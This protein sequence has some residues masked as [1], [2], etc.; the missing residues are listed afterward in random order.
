MTATD[1]L[2][3]LDLDRQVDQDQGTLFDEPRRRLRGDPSLRAG[4]AQFQAL[5][6]LAWE[7]APE[8]GER[9]VRQAVQQARRERVQGQ[10][11][12]TAG[13]DDLAREILLGRDR[14]RSGVPPWIWLLL[15]GASLG[16]GALAWH[17]GLIGPDQAL[18]PAPAAK[19]GD[20]AVSFEFPAQ[21]APADAALSSPGGLSAAAGADSEDVKH[22]DSASR[23]ARQ[24]LRQE[25]QQAQARANPPAPSKAPPAPPFAASDLVVEPAAQSY[26]QT[27]ALQAALLAPTPSD[28]VLAEARALQE[29]GPPARPT[30]VPQAKPTAMP[31][32]K[33]LSVPQ[34]R[35]TATP[36]PAPT[37][38]RVPAPVL[39]Q[40]AATAAAPSVSF[41]APSPSPAAASSPAAPSPDQAGLSLDSSDVVVGGRLRATLTLPEAK[42]VDLRLFDIGGK[43]VR[44]IADTV[45]GPGTVVYS[46]DAKDDNGQPLGAGTYYLRVMTAWF[47]R[48]EP[49]QIH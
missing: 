3:F 16:F 5:R 42:A 36:Q 9:L 30:S 14:Q 44:T 8:P 29:P 41:A 6:A 26:G 35:P 21:T 18:S 43:P 11:A 17:Q 28:V 33:P 2:L 32:A 34:A 25:L 13:S 40:P 22:E 4:W 31:K 48:V 39:A 37:A 1:A 12:R 38:T 49:I 10:L 7:C 47:S 24:L 19:T 15:L 20:D 45:A 46:V 23:Q 27:T